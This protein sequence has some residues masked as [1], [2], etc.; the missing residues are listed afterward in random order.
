MCLKDFLLIF[1]IFTFQIIH[2][3]RHQVKIVFQ[4]F[5][6]IFK[7]QDFFLFLFDSIADFCD[8]FFQRVE[9]HFLNIFKLKECK[10][11][12]DFEDLRIF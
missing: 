9:S 12:L 10:G 1:V 6:S 11:N 8:G 4:L 2:S 5:H 7:G 3:C